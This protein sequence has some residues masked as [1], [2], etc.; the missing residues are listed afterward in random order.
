M[1]TGHLDV[2]VL[3]S[4]W[5]TDTSS[6]THRCAH[7]AKVLQNLYHNTRA[8]PAVYAGLDVGHALLL[9]SQEAVYMHGPEAAL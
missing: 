8:I 5:L 7:L 6:G 4:M 9:R 3:H 2:H 1:M